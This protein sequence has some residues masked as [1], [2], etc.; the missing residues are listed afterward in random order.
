VERTYVAVPTARGS[1][2]VGPGWIEGGDLFGLDDARGERFV[3]AD[4]LAVPRPAVVGLPPLG[5]Q[6][7]TAG[8]P[9]PFALHEE[10]DRVRGTRPYRPGDRLRDVH[11]RQLARTGVVAV[12]D[13]ERTDDRRLTVL[14]D[15]RTAERPWLGIDGALA[16]DL[17]EAAAGVAR[18]ALRAG[19][20]VALLT[21]DVGRGGTGGIVPADAGSRQLGR[22]LTALGHLS[23][24]GAGPLEAACAAHPEVLAGREVVVI[25]PVVDPRMAAL[26]SQLHRLTRRTMLLTPFP[27]R[28]APDDVGSVA[29]C[30][31]PRRAP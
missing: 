18:S 1:W 13:R 12:L 2:R 28:A 20:S 10:A 23:V 25:S 21:G 31:L 11:Q 16:E 9:R 17:I 7:L 5:R 19:G 26:F 8:S 4:L 30:P 15:V 6:L 27:E 14:L 29:V 24:T 22:V 3:A